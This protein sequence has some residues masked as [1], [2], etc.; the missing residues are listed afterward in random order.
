MAERLG[1][2][3]GLVRRLIRTGYRNVRIAAV[4]LAAYLATVT[5]KE[6]P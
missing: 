2:S 3:P 6:T 1:V 4:D 5:T